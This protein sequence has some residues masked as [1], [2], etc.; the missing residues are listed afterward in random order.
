MVRL[1]KV[2]FTSFKS[3]PTVARSLWN[4]WPAWTV[5]SSGCWTCIWI[6]RFIGAPSLI[7][8]LKYSFAFFQIEIV[9]AYILGEA[10]NGIGY[11]NGIAHRI[12]LDDLVDESTVVEAVRE[13]LSGIDVVEGR[14]RV[15]HAN[16]Q[17]T[18][19]DVL[20]DMRVGGLI[21]ALDL[22]NRQKAV[23]HIQRA[24]EERENPCRGYLGRAPFDPLYRVRIV[25][26]AHEMVVVLFQIGAFEWYV[27]GWQ[28]AVGTRTCLVRRQPFG[29]PIAILLVWL[30]GPRIDDRHHRYHREERAE[31]LRQ[32]EA[33]RVPAGC[34]D[35]VRLQ[36]G[37]QGPCWRA[38]DSKQPLKRVNHVLG[39][40]L[41]AIVEFDAFTQ[42]EFPGQAIGGN[43]VIGC[44][45]RLHLGR[46]A[47]VAVKIVVGIQRVLGRLHV[48][49]LGRIE[50]GRQ[51][52]ASDE[53]AIFGSGCRLCTKCQRC[54]GERAELASRNLHCAF[55][56]GVADRVGAWGP[57]WSMRASAVPARA[58]HPHRR[59][60]AVSHTR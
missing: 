9:T 21:D 31:G 23:G 44:E 22:V 7:A 8:L 41:A 13:G 1:A 25:A 14:L 4:N 15:V 56:S 17:Q 52:L 37:L 29:A 11:R 35:R 49:D 32:R 53:H 5:C 48:E 39:D 50:V 47:F 57:D 58:R 60:A 45:P 43:R 38:A 33:D 59:R 2:S 55:L 26:P 24:V 18:H 12:A 3:M 30:D 20:R 34:A 36:D 40:Q 10:P 54:R 42:L 19:G 46:V 27:A 16:N 28:Q 51:I 6:G